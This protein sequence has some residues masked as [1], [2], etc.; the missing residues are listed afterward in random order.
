MQE[1]ICT[2]D[3]P[4][5]VYNVDNF[6]VSAA[7]STYVFPEPMQQKVIVIATIQSGAAGDQVQINKSLTQA[8]VNIFDKDGT[9]KTG[10]VDLYIGGH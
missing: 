4:E 6:P 5:T 7:G 1:L 9:A 10:E 8:T 3:V 2:F